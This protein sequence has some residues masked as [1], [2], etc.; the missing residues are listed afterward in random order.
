MKILQN[1]ITE[2]QTSSSTNFGGKLSF[3]LSVFPFILSLFT[4]VTY[5]FVTPTCTITII[6]LDPSPL[7]SEFQ[8]F[9]LRLNKISLLCVYH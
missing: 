6:I 3:I 1:E 9:I 7:N 4:A 2:T 8:H 5:V